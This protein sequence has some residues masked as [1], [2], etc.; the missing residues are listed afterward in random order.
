MSESPLNRL[1]FLKWVVVAFMVT[2][3]S[4]WAAPFDQFSGAIPLSYHRQAASDLVYQ[5][6]LLLPDEARELFES[7]VIG[8]LSLISPNENTILWKDE[9]SKP[10]TPSRLLEDDDLLEVIELVPRT[11]TLIGQFI[12]RALKVFPNGE[13]K[14]LRVVF[15]TKGHNNLLR[16]ALLE[17][18]GYRVPHIEHA[19]KIN[20][21]FKGVFSKNE[22]LKELKRGTFLEAD[23]WVL[24][25]LDEDSNIIQVQDVIILEDAEDEFYNLALGVIPSAKIQ[26]RRILNSLLVPYNLVD[27]PESVNL[28]TWISGRIF[29]KQLVLDYEYGSEFNTP[30]EDAKW[31]TR[32]ILSLDLED[33]KE[34]VSYGSYPEE[35]EVL[36]LNKILSRL[37]FLRKAF[38]LEDEYQKIPFDDSPSFGSRLK[39]GKLVGGV[40]WEGYAAHFAG[41]DPDDPLSLSE[42]WSFIGSK[43]IS[44]VITT[45][46]T[47]FNK[48]FVPRT[49]LQF[50]IF[51]HQ[52]DVAIKQ[53]IDYLKTGQVSKV[54]FGFW[55]KKFFDI[56]IIANREVIAGNYMGSD[57]IVQLADTIGTT[58]DLGIYIGTDGLPTNMIAQGN[59]KLN[60]YRTY[61]SLKPIKSIKASL[62][63]PLR[64][65]L[66]PLEKF[67]N[68]GP[69]EELEKLQKSQENPQIIAEKASH[70]L[71]EFKESIG[72]G[73][74]IIIQ[75]GIG[76]D[77]AFLVGQGITDYAQAY[78]KLQDKMTVITRLH[79]YRA[80]EDAFHIYNDPALVNQLDVSLTL[81]A[82]TQI[83]NIG[84]QWNKGIARTE[85]FNINLGLDTLDDDPFRKNPDFFD[86]V[87]A[88]TRALKWSRLDK[89]RSVQKP[90]T[91]YHDFSERKFSLDF[92][93]L[94]HLRGKQ[95]DQISIVHPSGQQK[96]FY[97]YTLGKR[98]GHDYQSFS[99]ELI[100]SLLHELTEMSEYVTIRSTNSG[101]PADTFKGKSNS[102]VVN[103]EGLSSDIQ[104]D[105]IY[106]GI[107]YRYKGWSATPKNIV[108]IFNKLNKKVANE[109]FPAEA[110][111]GSEKVRFYSVNMNISFYEMAFRHWLKVDRSV[112]RTAISKYYLSKVSDAQTF[113][114]HVSRIW[115]KFSNV[116][117]FYNQNK[118]TQFAQALAKIV[119][120]LEDSFSFEGLTYLSGGVNNLYVSGNL[121]GFRSRLENG[122]RDV[123]SHSVGMIGS[124]QPQGPLRTIQ[125]QSGISEGEFLILWLMNRY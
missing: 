34:I 78:L 123:F 27:I 10:L 5:G 49:D 64:N 58:L 19:P 54:P 68:A 41:T 4:L 42:M 93:W 115:T 14:V 111:N 38:D 98:T 71:K 48:R 72:V 112:V 59:V 76:P 37:I 86:N 13:K 73:E 124:E 22:M 24:N 90:W 82:Y 89:L 56:N 92:L 47:E 99:L 17:K 81:K 43:V 85:F 33:W 29:N 32:R 7:G 100:D 120:D 75:T 36:V 69:L 23:R 25:D 1:E 65:M 9:L 122:D 94:R 46:I 60:L 63:E 102:R 44:N 2:M 35:V 101:N 12:L 11:E 6:Q 16:K 50:A 96:D 117:K 53:F 62:K 119:D 79:I 83:L 26:G 114:S 80:G 118:A 45:L 28:M 106:L 39:K 3:G 74:S 87:K 21:K 40:N 121:S 8:D 91:I 55:H 77:L 103:V 51:D 31:I 116:Q 66:V 30:Y 110:L 20:L 61:T 113:N 97:R 107:D 18:I 67:L 104:L 88:L 108:S 109:I 70:I 57:N 125:V 52:L 95:Q 105:S 84:G 15:D